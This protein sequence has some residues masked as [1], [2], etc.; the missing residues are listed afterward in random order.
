MLYPMRSG[1]ILAIATACS[2]TAPPPAAV[3]ATPED[4]CAYVA[5]HLLS[6]LTADA[7]QAPAEEVDRVRAQFN[8]RCR[9]DG[10]T[11]AAQRCFLDLTNKG[12]VDR[13]ASQLTDAQRAALDTPPPAVGRGSARGSA[14]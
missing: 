14:E 11:P 12:E 3:P 8:T 4:R 10:W 9:D 6:L 5:D 2:S 13:C 1:L 7:Q